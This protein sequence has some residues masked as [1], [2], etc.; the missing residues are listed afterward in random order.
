MSMDGLSM[1][2]MCRELAPLIDGKIDKVQQPDR[3]ALL[4]TVR[5]PGKTHRLLLSTHAENGRIQL[6]SGPHENPADAP[7]FCMLL[8]RRLT[9][10][11]I[12]AIEQAGLDRVAIF[13]ISARTEL[14]DDVSYRLIV[15]LMGKHSNIALLAGDGTVL[16][17]IRHVGPQMSS[18]RLMLPGV[19]YH[20][21]PAQAKQDPL[22]LSAEAFAAAFAGCASPSKRM[23]ERFQGVS[24]RTAEALFAL[25]DTPEGV[26]A[27]LTAVNDGS[28]PPAILEDPLGEP[29]AVFPFVPPAP[30]AQL[31]STPTLSEAY[32][33]F[34][35]R[36]DAAVRIQRAS[37]SLRRIL[38]NHL[39]R[40]HNKLAAYADTMASETLFEEYRLFGELIT[41]NLHRLNRGA[42]MAVLENYYQDPPEAVAVPLEP[43][44]SPQE[45]AQRYFKR[46]RKS[47]T[48]RAYAEQQLALVQS[49]IAY[50]EGQLDNIDKCAA[51]YELAEIREELAREGYVRPERRRGG[52][53]RAP[54]S[55]P[56]RFLSSDGIWIY[57][58]K[59][60]RQNDE[61]TLKTAAGTQ[62]WLHAKNIPG[63][64]VIIG[65]EGM[66]PAQTLREAAMVAAFYSRA[67][68]SASVPVDYTERKN[69]KKPSGARPGMVI[70]TTNRTLFVTPDA[71]RVNAM[72]QAA[73]EK[74]KEN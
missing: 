62:L 48:A 64:H 1:R 24:R 33:L 38:D 63:S 46:Y 37:Q 27:L 43:T 29:V 58:G 68:S 45:N 54:L 11:R 49:E 7:A 2:A 51:L 66:P 39:S 56:M 40:A 55:K 57:A 3:D 26:Y 44:L 9:G 69:V 18:V 21:P 70:Y 74:K 36:R 41:A 25:G 8:R 42:P 22:A 23:T 60:N 13:T 5:C 30:R 53:A 12:A 50:L 71:A 65:M 31:R 14:Y 15:E 35:A 6:T 59:N 4:L 10:G 47:K 20:A 67:R 32:D 34:Y 52:G 19:A 73:N 17:C 16:D 72:A 61:L 28:L